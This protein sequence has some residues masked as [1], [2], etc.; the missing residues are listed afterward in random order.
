MGYKLLIT[1]GPQCVIWRAEWFR[2]V[3]LYYFMQHLARFPQFISIWLIKDTNRRNKQANFRTRF[4][5]GGKNRIG[6]ERMNDS[7]DTYL[8]RWISHAAYVN[9]EIRNEKIKVKC[10]PFSYIP[11]DVGCHN[12][13]VYWRVFLKT[14]LHLN[15]IIS[16]V[17]HLMVFLRRD[18]NI[19][20]WVK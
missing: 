19:K 8:F 18:F 7:R 11:H 20:I 13:F 15:G 9:R 12:G 14:N 5:F 4:R 10:V 16:M 3:D 1:F 6:S 2:T 17:I